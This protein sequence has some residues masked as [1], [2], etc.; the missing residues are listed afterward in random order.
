M[1]SPDAKDEI[2][3][4]AFEM[5]D[6]EDVADLFQAPKCQRGT[7]QLPY[8]S[9]DDLRRKLEQPPAGMHRLVAVAPSGRVVGMIGLHPNTGRRGHTAS[10]GMFVHDDVQ[11]KGIGGELLRALIDFTEKWL[12]IR[13]LE[14]TVYVDNEP[15]IRLYKRHGFVEEGRLREYAMR[16]GVYIDAYTMARLAHEQR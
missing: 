7:L 11:G 4:R 13:R 9:R 3:I 14:L 2:L 1:D 10:I 15:A 6:W 12:S 5:A 8:Q 16:D